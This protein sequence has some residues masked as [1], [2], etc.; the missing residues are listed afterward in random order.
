MSLAYRNLFQDKVR[1]TLSIAGV[2]LAA[3]LILL[4]NGFLN[5]LYRQVSS[6]LDHAPGPIVVAQDG[7]SNFLGVTSLLPSGTADAARRVSGVSQVVPVLSRMAILDLHG[8]RQ[9]VF[10]VGYDP[11][12]GGGPWRLA[13]GREPQTDD[14]MVFDSVL[15]QRYGTT[16]G[17]KINIL[18]RE[19]RVV[20][21]SEGTTSWMTSFVFLR[22]TAAESLL[23]APGATSFLLVAPSNGI[24]PEELRGRLRGLPDTNVLLKSE[25]I[26]ND[27]QLLISFFSTSVRLMVGIAFLVGILVVGLV[28]YT[29]TVERQREYGVLKA[30]GIRN[31]KLYRVVITQ[32]LIA[33]GAGSLAGVGLAFSAAQLIMRVRPE[34][35]VTFE[36]PTV[37]WALLAGL[38][39][40]LVAALYPAR[41]MAKLAPADVF[42]R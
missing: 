23:L 17:D 32:A 40:A 2:A 27:S 30:I 22:K 15:A 31:A 21:L 6:Y 25:I 9:P 10:L 5:G 14:E 8:K 26:N 19:F 18:G 1:L 34:Y 3:M 4:L 41:A 13:E 28:I 12:I 20:G 36:P 24:S 35:L 33:A 11:V 42:R 37:G 16:L 29:A 39:M 38:V 7:V